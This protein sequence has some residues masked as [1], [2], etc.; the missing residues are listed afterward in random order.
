MRRPRGWPP[1][2]VR[3]TV[4]VVSERDPD[5]RDEDELWRSIVD[6]YGDRAELSPE[7]RPPAAPLP[8]PVTGPVAETVFSAPFEDPDPEPFV[9]P[10]PPPVPLPR[11]PRLIAWAGVFVAPLLMLVS[12]LSWL[13]MPTLVGL[14]MVGWFVGGFGYLVATMPRGPRDPGDDGAVHRGRN[15]MAG[16]FGHMQ[17]VPDGHPCECGGSGCWEQYSSGNALVRFARARI[18]REP[19]SLEAACHG[20]LE[21]LTGPMVTEAAMRGDAVA[22]AAFHEVGTWLGVGIANLVAAFDPD[23]VVVGGGVSAAGDLL[24][25]PARAAMAESLVGA[26]HRVVPPVHEA[27]LGPQ[28]GLVGAAALARATLRPNRWA[29]ANGP[30]GT[31]PRVQL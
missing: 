3:P 25:A 28:A 17:V 2:R 1:A 22:R 23:C 26:A 4:D 27:Q 24:L 5:A 15:G 10:D 14:A 9:A 30:L 18:G 21:R 7:D 20:D 19:T 13:P 8:D 16:E 11:G 31:A 12:A 6:N 29:I